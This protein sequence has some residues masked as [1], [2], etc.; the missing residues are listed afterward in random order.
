MTLF[1]KYVVKDR[2][3]LISLETIFEENAQ[4][5]ASQPGYKLIKVPVN[6]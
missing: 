6:R 1:Y 3:G 5:R 2:Y 4:K